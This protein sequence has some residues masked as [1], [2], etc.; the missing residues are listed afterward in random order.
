VNAQIAALVT[1][2]LSLVGLAVIIGKTT[3]VQRILD[4]RVRSVEARLARIERKLERI[5]PKSDS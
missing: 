4:F 3:S 1:G 5:R 2:V